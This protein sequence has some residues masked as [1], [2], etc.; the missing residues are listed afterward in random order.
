MDCF[1]HQGFLLST[2]LKTKWLTET[3]EFTMLINDT[4]AKG[5]TL[6]IKHVADKYG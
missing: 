1:C 4:G 5:Q 2:C 3:T 6:L